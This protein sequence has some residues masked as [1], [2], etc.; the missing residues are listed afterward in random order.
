MSVTMEITAIGPRGDRI[1]YV[2]ISEE[3]AVSRYLSDYARPDTTREWLKE[4]DQIV[5][6]C[7][8]DGAFWT[9]D[10]GESGGETGHRFND[11][12]PEQIVCRRCFMK[13]TIRGISDG[14]KT[15]AGERIR[16]KDL[17]GA[18]KILREEIG[19]ELVEAKA[20]CMHVTHETG[21]CHRCE[22]PLESGGAQVCRICG[23]L[24]LNWE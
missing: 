16:S 10:A 20:L 5:R 7:V 3:E 15:R 17:L 13:W 9:Y 24:C 19:M 2:G 1:A 6:F 11:E 23:T 22:S 14:I 12:N 18:M 21:V 4:N 8:I